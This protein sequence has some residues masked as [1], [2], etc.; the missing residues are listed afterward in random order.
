MYDDTS[1]NWNQWNSNEKLKEKS[2]NYTSK[3]FDRLTTEDSYTWNITRNTESAA[4]R[5]LKPERWGVTA[6]SREVPGRK[7]VTRDNNNYNNNNLITCFLYR[8]TSQQ[9]KDRVITEMA[10]LHTKGTLLGAKQDG[11]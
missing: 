6:G 8:G 5:N 10:V 4:V 2:G 3:T 1:H 9:Y 11:V 7:P